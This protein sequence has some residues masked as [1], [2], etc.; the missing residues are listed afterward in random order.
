MLL[1]LIN[2]VCISS[3]N[4]QSAEDAYNKLMAD[5]ATVSEVWSNYEYS[6]GKN[7]PYEVEDVPGLRLLGVSKDLRFRKNGLDSVFMADIAEYKGRPC[8]YVH[9]NLKFIF[10]SDQ[11]FGFILSSNLTKEQKDRCI[12]CAKELLPFLPSGWQDMLEPNNFESCRRTS[13][14]FL[15]NKRQEARLKR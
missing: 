15:V 9:C 10:Y 5:R 7:Y 6:S 8:L 1:L 3:D 11:K 14:Q 2:Q 13:Y 12:N 4:S